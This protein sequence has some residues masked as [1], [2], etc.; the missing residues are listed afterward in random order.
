VVMTSHI[1]QPIARCFRQL[2]LITVCFKSLPFEAARTVSRVDY[3][4]GL[5]TGAPQ[6][7]LD[8]FKSVAAAGG[9]CGFRRYDKVML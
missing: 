9:I 8:R 4:N 7:L 2:R 1:N 5:L 3:C 6:Y